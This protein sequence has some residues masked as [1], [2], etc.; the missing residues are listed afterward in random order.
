MHHVDGKTVLLKYQLQR[1]GNARFIL[2]DKYAHR[3]HLTL[4]HSAPSQNQPETILSAPHQ[5][6]RFFPIVATLQIICFA[7][8]R[9]ARMEVIVFTLALFFSCRCFVSNKSF[10]VGPT[11]SRRRTSDARP[12]DLCF[13][14]PCHLDNGNIP[15]ISEVHNRADAIT[16]ST[17]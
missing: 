16:T 8:A 13:L 10:C 17:I 3:I 11:G 6:S 1:L 7:G 5:K 4:Q 15:N 9:P 2:G 14:R 12:Y